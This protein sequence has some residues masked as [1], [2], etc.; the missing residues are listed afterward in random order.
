[1][2]R[3]TIRERRI[4]YEEVSDRYYT[5]VNENNS[6]EVF[7]ILPELFRTGNA[8]PEGGYGPLIKVMEGFRISAKNDCVSLLNIFMNP[9]PNTYENIDI[10]R[11]QYNKTTL[12][13]AI[14]AG[15]LNA[16]EFLLDHGADPYIED[17]SRGAA[18]YHACKKNVLMVKLL[19]RMIPNLDMNVLT[20]E[21]NQTLLMAACQ[22]GAFDVVN[23]LLNNNFGGDV[24]AVDMYGSPASFFALSYPEIL[25][26]LIN[27]GAKINEPIRA[28]EEFKLAVVSNLLY[29][30]AK[31]GNIK[32]VEILLEN[33][34]NVNATIEQ[35]FTP[36]MTSA[37]NGDYDIAKLLLDS[38]ADVNIKSSMGVTAL[39]IASAYNH[40]KIKNL[41]A[42]RSTQI[43]KRGLVPEVE[44]SSKKKSIGGRKKN[45]KRR[46]KGNNRKSRKTKR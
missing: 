8:Y 28:K 10:N 32:S 46:F 1:M 23:Y 21:I 42:E 43:G 14:D 13:E 24:N 45:T 35:N 30:A 16:V 38:G 22:G 6:Q 19:Q 7:A 2:D 41:L 40:T 20:R 31:K 15:S 4:A 33:G 18:L 34:A 3:N 9:P 44:T 12:I 26:T 11:L 25:E 39:S 29:E 27:H 37:V 36:L 17:H 5:A